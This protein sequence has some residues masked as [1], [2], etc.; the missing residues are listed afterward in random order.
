[1][2]ARR[3]IEAIYRFVERLVTRGLQHLQVDFF[4]GEPLLCKNQTYEFCARCIDLMG[5]N[6][7]AGITTNAV[8]LDASCFTRLIDLNCRHFQITLDGPKAVHDTVRKYADGT[9]THDKIIANLSDMRNHLGEFEVVI[10]LHVT[11]KSYTWMP[12]L[13]D[14]L[15]PIIQGDE[16]F[17]VDFHPL[18][19]LGGANRESNDLYPTDEYLDAMNKY[20]KL[21]PGHTPYFDFANSVCYASQPNSFIFLP[22]GDIAKCTVSLDK[23]VVGH[24]NNDGTLKMDARV[25]SAWCIGSHLQ[26]TGVKGE[27]E[28]EVKEALRCPRAVLAKFWNASNRVTAVTH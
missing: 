2:M 28:N 23:G 9:G 12:E 7:T 14:V 18:V 8:E 6:F 25:L 16:R 19:N 13:I 4:G 3:T 27:N 10:R 22:N 20:R 5:M 15:L 24:L 1:M 17:V 21:I 26:K 11:K